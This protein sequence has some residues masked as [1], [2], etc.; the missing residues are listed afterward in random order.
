MQFDESS[1]TMRADVLKALTTWACDEGNFD[2]IGDVQ[3]SPSPSSAPT[4]K[5]SA[6][7]TSKPTPCTCPEP[8]SEPTR[9]PSLAPSIL[10]DDDDDDGRSGKLSKA[11]ITGIAVGVPLFVI[12]LIVVTID[13]IRLRRLSRSN[14]AARPTMEMQRTDDS[15]SNPIHD[16]A[17]EVTKARRGR[18][19]T[20]TESA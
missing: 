3:P 5:P 18:S 19:S 6:S 11:G 2:C 7:P 15:N 4:K 9:R 8:S 13:N 17:A 10:D 20:R 14:A 16:P 1:L 12:L